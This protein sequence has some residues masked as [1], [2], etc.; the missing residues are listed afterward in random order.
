MDKINPKLIMALAVAVVF[1]LVFKLSQA[2]A[3]YS[4]EKYWKTATIEDAH[5]I[6]QSALEIGNKNGPVLMWAASVVDDPQILSVL[7]SRGAD[8][9]EMDP[10]FG[11]TA[12][13]AA[14]FQN[15]SPYVIDALV[16]NGAVVNEEIGRLKKTPLL[17]A[18]ETNNASVTQRLLFHGADRYAKDSSGKTAEMIAEQWNNQSVV[19]LYKM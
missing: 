13:S 8:V 10:M 7:I 1:V 17:L 15:P 16:E 19:A 3:K 5:N 6:P 9:V 14:A 2:D 12:L 11:A 4:T 18:A